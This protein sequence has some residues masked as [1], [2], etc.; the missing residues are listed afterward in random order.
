MYLGRCGQEDPVGCG[1]DA[2]GTDEKSV[3]RAILTK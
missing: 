2:P 3:F 1:V